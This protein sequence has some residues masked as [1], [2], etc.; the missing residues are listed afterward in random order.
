[1]GSAASIRA[2]TTIVA[3]NSASEAFPK[4]RSSHWATA[5]VPKGVSGAG[6][7]PDLTRVKPPGAWKVSILHESPEHL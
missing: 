1:L 3:A 4:T 7:M 6:V 2:E 5:A